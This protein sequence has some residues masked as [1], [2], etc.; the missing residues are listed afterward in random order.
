MTVNE[1]GNLENPE[2]FSPDLRSGIPEFEIW[3]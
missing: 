3:I 1:M 2:I